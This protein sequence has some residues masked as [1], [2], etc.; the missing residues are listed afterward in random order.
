M[1]L[2]K[3]AVEDGHGEVVGTIA[4]FVVDID[5]AEELFTHVDFS[6]IILTRTWL[7]GHLVVESTLEIGGELFD[8]VGFHQSSPVRFS[9]RPSSLKTRRYDIVIFNLRR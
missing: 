6:G 5:D 1:T 7:D 2:S 8:F 4:I 3:I 9:R